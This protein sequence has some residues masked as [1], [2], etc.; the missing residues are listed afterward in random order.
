MEPVADTTTLIDSYMHWLEHRAR[1]R[2]LTLRTYRASLDQFNQFLAGR[3][4]NDLSA[5]VFEEF[6]WRPRRGGTAPAANTARRDL[7]AVKQFMKWAQ[8]RKH[9]T[10]TEY[11]IA[12][13]PSVTGRRPK[14]IPDEVWR[15]LD[16]SKLTMD[17]RVWLGL[18]YFAGLRRYEIVTVG[19]SQVD[20]DRRLLV[21]L[22]RKGGSVM[23][24]PYG[25]LFEAVQARLPWVCEGWED[26][27][28]LIGRYKALRGPQ[29]TLW[30][31]DN[32]DVVQAATALNKRLYRLL[33]HH[34]LPTDAF[35][36]HQLRHS[37]A[38]NLFRCGFDARYVS[39]VMSHV[40]ME[41]TRSYTDVSA[42]LTEWLDENRKKKSD[43]QP[44]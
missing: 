1:K 27:P 37:F 24:V 14:P 4:L 7:A 22:E 19:A 41:M 30:P 42:Y 26:W 11:M 25:L 40:N 6:A 32:P 10:N 23:D 12:V 13:A 18:G 16:P 29:E 2:P 21:T 31:C 28:A 43:D 5:D 9:T 38:T 15:Q 44:A 36:P 3:T 20:P 8:A 35:T 33:P 39:D 17:D 34:G